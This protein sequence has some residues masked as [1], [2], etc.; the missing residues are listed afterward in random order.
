MKKTFTVGNWIS[1]G[2]VLLG[3]V[4]MYVD[5][6]MPSGKYQQ[7]SMFGF[8]ITR[9]ICTFFAVEIVVFGIILMPL[10]F[11][12]WR[13]ILVLQLLL[14]FAIGT[15]LLTL[16]IHKSVVKEHMEITTKKTS[17]IDELHRTLSAA[18]D[19]VPPQYYRSFN[20]LIEDVKYSD[21]I[22]A[23]DLELEETRLKLEVFELCEKIKQGDVADIEIRI[24]NATNILKIR[25]ERLY[26]LKCK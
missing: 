9:H 7:F 11:I 15:K 17:Y 16:L 26:S 18:S 25:N 14:I 3:F 22:S 24:K 4:M 2:G 12:D 5:T 20:R 8:P 13:I 1:Y 10:R 6:W 23:P 19:F 21:P